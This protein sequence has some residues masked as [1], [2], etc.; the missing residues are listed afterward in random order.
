MPKN[1]AAVWRNHLSKGI[2]NSVLGPLFDAYMAPAQASTQLILGFSGFHFT[3]IAREALNSRL[4]LALDDI[5]NAGGQGGRA[6]A[7][8]GAALPAP[9]V[10]AL[11]GHKIM[12]EYNKPGTHP[13]LRP[14][15]DMMIKGGRSIEGN[16]HVGEG[17]D[18][19]AHCQ[20]QGQ[21]GKK[22]SA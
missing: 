17:G 14:V 18:A 6:G 16:R 8:L 5:A 21:A 12:Q 1:A 10:D 19:Q 2:R 7:H 3:T 22:S 15:L 20:P 9:V 4:A 11:F 13:G